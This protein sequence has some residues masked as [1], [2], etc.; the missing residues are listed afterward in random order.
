[1]PIQSGG[2]TSGVYLPYS[3]V[4]GTCTM[5]GGGIY[6]EDN[7]STATNITLSAGTDASGNLTQIYTIKQGSTTTTVTVPVWN[8][9]PT[10]HLPARPTHKWFPA[11][12]T[13]LWSVFP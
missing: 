2:A 9:N 11:A 4:G 3:C 5:N 12:H 6:V 10:P 8:H 13:K 1:M 7:S